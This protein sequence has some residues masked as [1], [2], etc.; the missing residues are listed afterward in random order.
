MKVIA[1]IC[2]L[3]AALMVLFAL[4]MGL[5]NVIPFLGVSRSINFIHF[6]NTLLLFTIAALLCDKK[7]E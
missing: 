3:L 5:F 1:W 7:K 4:I 2:G 6:A